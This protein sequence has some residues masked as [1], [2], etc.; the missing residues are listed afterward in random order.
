VS[1]ITTPS[2]AA[3]ILSY[4]ALGEL[5]MVRDSENH[6]FPSGPVENESGPAYSI[7][8]IPGK[9]QGIIALRKIERFEVFMIDAP[10]LILNRMVVEEAS[11]QL[12]RQIL[13]QA[14]AQL[15]S[16]TKRQVLMLAKSTGGENWHD[17]FSTNAAGITISEES[18]LGLFLEISVSPCL[19]G[20][21]DLESLTTSHVL[22]RRG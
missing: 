15:P 16:D 19:A 4:G 18:H 1:I 17:I 5:P 9:G 2:T 20:I 22:L 8:E 7:Q 14:F 11:G 3:N 13:R 6:P 10:I 21:Y 12:R